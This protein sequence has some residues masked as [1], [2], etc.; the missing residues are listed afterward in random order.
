[1][2]VYSFARQHDA[3]QEAQAVKCRDETMNSVVFELLALAEQSGG[4]ALKQTVV[5]RKTTN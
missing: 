4:L 3:W 1:M 2:A 5:R